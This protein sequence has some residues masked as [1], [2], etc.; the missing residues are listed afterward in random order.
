VFRSWDNPRAN[1]Y[2]KMNDIP[3][4]WG[5]AVNV[6]QMAFGNSGDAFRHRR[7]LH[8][9]PRHRREEAD[10]RVPDQRPGRGRRR[11]RPHPFP[12]QPAEGPDARGVRSVRRH[13]HP[14]ENYYRDMQDMEFTIEDGKLFMLQ[15]RNGKRTAQ[16]A[17]Q[18]ACDLV[19][20]GM[21]DRAQAV[22]R[23]EPK[24]LDTLLHPQFDAAALKAAEAIGKGLAA[25]P[26]SAC[27]R[28]VFT[29]EDAEEKVKDKRWKKVVLVRLE[30]S[31]EDI[32]GMQVSQGILTVR[33]G[34]TSHAAVVARGM[35]TCCVSGCGD[36]TV[37]MDEEPR[38]LS[39]TAT[40]S[41]RATGSPRRLHRQ[42]LRRADRHRRRHRQQELH[43]LHGLGRC[44]ASAQG[45]D[46][47]RQPAR[48]A[49]GRRFGAE[50]IGLCRTE[51]MFFAEDRIKAMREMICA[52]HVEDRKKALAKLEPDQQGDF[53]AMY[54]SWATAR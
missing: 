38:P 32:V 46:Q 7:R 3:Y 1:V 22:L 9:Q 15:T 10:G 21:I 44:R 11:R 52:R 39:S 18:I 2:R 43:P 31:P 54:R 16:A 26:G 47:R 40:P 50:G 35:G 8:A 19:D 30:T 33:G 17:L 34:M 4:E 20:E 53:E 41:R 51:H 37:V 14:L 12:D 24:Q 27:G 45:H 6:Q 49:A 29:A 28:V 25:S 23:V 36:N 13:R 42:H 5:T 48:R